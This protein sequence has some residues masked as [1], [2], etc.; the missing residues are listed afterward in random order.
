MRHSS[1]IC[2]WIAPLLVVAGGALGGDAAAFVWPNVPEQVEKALTSGDVS[3]RRIAAA[4]LVDLPPEIA[5]RLI[6]PAL[7]DPDVEVRL[8]V[9][10]AF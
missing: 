8:R 5:L 2:R 1:T 6:P 9:A 4:R 10:Q 7:G 3:E